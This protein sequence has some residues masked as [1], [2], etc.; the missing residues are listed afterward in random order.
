MLGILFSQF[1]KTKRHPV[2]YMCVSL[3]IIY[4][5]AFVLITKIWPHLSPSDLLQLYKYLLS[6]ACLFCLGLLVPLLVEEDR[7]IGF[8]HQIRV[9]VKRKYI[10]LGQWIFCILLLLGVLIWT[11]ILFCL[12]FSW[13]GNMT[14]F[15]LY[16]LQQVFYFAP[17][18]LFFLLMA[19]L[20]GVSST[21]ILGSFFTLSGILLSSTGLGDG[22][23]FCL[24][25]LWPIK[26][27]FMANQMNWLGSRDLAIGNSLLILFLWLATTLWYDRWEGLQRMED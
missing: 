10:W 6:V 15:I 12:V 22:I 5:L 26:L 27:A 24:P 3:P 17:V 4:I 18:L 21:F 2:R 1:K 19:H 9:G 7:E 14:S 13:W 20:K 23:W 16:S 11:N 8:A 25:W